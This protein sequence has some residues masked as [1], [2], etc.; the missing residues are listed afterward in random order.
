MA[1]HYY[2]GR[3]ILDGVKLE[4]FSEEDLRAL[5]YATMD[6]LMNPG[7]QVSDAEARNIFK[8]AGCQVDEKTNVV[9]I[10]RI[11]S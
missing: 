1:N 8:Q 11:C 7:V 2:P 5:H 10:P 4:L 3:D 9:K 6:V